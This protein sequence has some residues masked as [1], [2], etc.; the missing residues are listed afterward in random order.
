MR[1]TS[2]TGASQGLTCPMCGA[3]LGSD[4]LVCEACGEDLRR[5]GVVLSS[6]VRPVVR[7]ERRQRPS[8]LMALFVA[9]L[10]LTV[11]LVGLAHL[12]PVTPGG[13]GATSRSVR[14]IVTGSAQRALHW[15]EQVKGRNNR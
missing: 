11:A 4:T 2:A 3:R 1:G 14:V 6:G 10:M 15:I 8:R 12:A 13:W 5:A 7:Q 9:C